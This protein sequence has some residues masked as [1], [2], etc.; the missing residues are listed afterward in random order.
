M[1]DES[2]KRLE[3]I[4]Y[5]IDAIVVVETT[6]TGVLIKIQDNHNTYVEGRIAYNNHGVL[7]LREQ[8][9][10]EVSERDFRQL[11][12]STYAFIDTTEAPLYLDIRRAQNLI[13]YLLHGFHV[14][15]HLINGYKRIEGRFELPPLD[16]L[17]SFPHKKLGE[18]KAYL[19]TLAMQTPQTTTI[20]IRGTSAYSL[21]VAHDGKMIIPSVDPYITGEK[22]AE[23]FKASLSRH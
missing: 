12:K 9:L 8:S 5:E 1:N 6:Q 13:L 18:V 10:A 3:D 15:E 22:E 16:C 17:P 21:F 19:K 7:F 2:I 23:S 11:C 20:R 4:C 14:G